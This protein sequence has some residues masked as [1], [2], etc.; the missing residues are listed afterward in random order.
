MFTVGSADRYI[1]RYVE[2][3]TKA[4]KRNHVFGSRV[5]LSAPIN[6]E[7]WIVFWW[8]IKIQQSYMS[9]ECML[10]FSRFCY[11][12]A[13]TSIQNFLQLHTSHSWPLT[14]KSTKTDFARK[15]IPILQTELLANTRNRHRYWDG[16]SLCQY[17]HGGNGKANPKWL[18]PLK[19]VLHN[20]IFPNLSRNFVAS[21]VARKIAQC[22]N[23]PETIHATFLLPPRLRE[24]E[25]SSTLGNASGKDATTFSIVD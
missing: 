15:L 20:A 22:N 2:L 16:C 8:T 21:Q 25:I 11:N 18:R 10:S 17:F 5:G 3:I 14:E 1:D 9:Q 6:T 19:P 13:L 12:F 24:K 4:R 23:R 7:K